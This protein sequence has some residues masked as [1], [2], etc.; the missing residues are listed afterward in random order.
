MPAISLNKTQDSFLSFFS[1]FVFEKP[2]QSMLECK[3]Y[4]TAAYSNILR[5]F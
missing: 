1:H 4:K 2:A 3:Y 5:G